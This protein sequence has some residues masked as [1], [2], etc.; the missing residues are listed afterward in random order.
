MFLAKCEYEKLR[1]VIIKRGGEL[2]IGTEIIT[3]TEDGIYRQRYIGMKDIDVRKIIKLHI[4]NNGKD[5]K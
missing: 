4:K 5:V 3:A 2:L 1:K